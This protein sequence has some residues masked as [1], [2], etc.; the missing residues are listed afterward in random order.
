[1]PP[2]GWDVRWIEVENW[3]DFGLNLTPVLGRQDVKVTPE[4]PTGDELRD[5]AD[6]EEEKDTVITLDGH[7]VYCETC[8]ADSYILEPNDY[9]TK[10]TVYYKTHRYSS[11]DDSDDAVVQ[12]KFESKN[13]NVKLLGT[14]PTST[15]LNDRRGDKDYRGTIIGDK[16]ESFTFTWEERLMGFKS[17]DDNGFL[18]KLEPYRS[19]KDCN[20]LGP[21]PDPQAA[22]APTTSGDGAD[23][24]SNDE[25][26]DAAVALV[27]AFGVLGALSVALF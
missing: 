1:M 6:A 21:N 19:S 17:Y 10:M 15:K 2:Y 14:A 12:V 25:S 20:V 26:D 11:G 24:G 13:G 18:A 16:E 27:S 7:A 8:T 9:I 22:P 23:D 5:F 3:P 4:N